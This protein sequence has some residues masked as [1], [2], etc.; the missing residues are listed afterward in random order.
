M[1]GS[2]ELKEIGGSDDGSDDD[3]TLQ[4]VEQF[5][6]YRDKVLNRTTLRFVF[7]V[8]FN[9]LFYSLVL[10][11]WLGTRVSTTSHTLDLTSV[12]QLKFSLDGCY[13]HIRQEQ[14][15]DGLVRVAIELE[16]QDPGVKVN[17]VTEGNVAKV[18]VLD[19][20][21]LNERYK[22]YHCSVRVGVPSTVVLPSTE[23]SIRGF[24]S[25][26][27]SS[28][29]Q[30][31]DNNTV[32]FRVENPRYT[33]LKL[34]FSGFT[35]GALDL[36]FDTGTA[37]FMD[38]K[39]KKGADIEAKQPS[40]NVY[41]RLLQP[42][43]TIK[44]QPSSL[45][46]C[47][48]GRT[49]LCGNGTGVEELC[50]LQFG[51]QSAPAPSVTIKG[52][53]VVHVMAA[54]ES[55]LSIDDFLLSSQT[56]PTANTY[57]QTGRVLPALHTA[58]IDQIKDAAKSD[59][60]VVFV[61]GAGAPDVFWL[62]SSLSFYL[63]VPSVFMDVFTWRLLSPSSSVVNVTLQTP[64]CPGL[65]HNGATT[66]WDTNLENTVSVYQLLSSSFPPGALTVFKDDTLVQIKKTAFNGQ[67][68]TEKLT[69]ASE[70]SALSMIVLNFALALF[71]SVYSVY[72]LYW[73]FQSWTSDQLEMWGQ[74][75]YGVSWFQQREKIRQNIGYFFWSEFLVDFPGN[76]DRSLWKSFMTVCVHIVCI[77]LPV[78]PLMVATGLFYNSQYNRDQ[79]EP[80]SLNIGTTSYHDVAFC[81]L[82]LI[83]AQCITAQIQ[84]SVYYLQLQH[85]T[86]F[87]WFTKL[88]KAVFALTLGMS[89]FYLSNVIFWLLLGIMLKP[90]T[91]LPLASVVLVLI[92]HILATYTR[93]SNLKQDLDDQIE[94]A[95]E[96]ADADAEVSKQQLSKQL[97]TDP[98]MA[99]L[100]VIEVK[101]VKKMDT[102]QLMSIVQK[103]KILEIGG[104]NCSF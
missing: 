20:R 31:W 50:D 35:M 47:L 44:P 40:A 57:S 4:T 16:T 74:A 21:A 98:K 18:E 15:T 65:Q 42:I 1:P 25:S 100:G 89:V 34:Y 45:S 103:S 49:V 2:V 58:D 27:I 61:E 29:G 10:P 88:Y 46:S 52:Q 75:K 93:V 5:P 43:R 104:L 33:A 54:R 60:A 23:F 39:I 67:F 30:N 84:L 68:F 79:L 102:K 95:S 8:G 96:E 99:E 86:L 87:R 3:S 92:G 48:T 41:M 28:T 64:F 72:A 78:L 82:L 66:R 91:V 32:S 37:Y 90:K 22:D 85:I 69:L 56:L 26:V 9:L 101:D 81:G 17:V 94:E 83:V 19:K 12:K 97:N 38:G 11:Q 55:A 36:A 13:T 53:G 70:A 14:I 63:V 80:Y 62:S 76:E 59:I 7:L 77:F 6:T 71:S 51:Q 73:R 24:L